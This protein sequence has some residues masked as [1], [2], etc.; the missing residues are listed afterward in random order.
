MFPEPPDGAPRQLPLVRSQLTT[1]VSCGTRRRCH[2]FGIFP[3]SCFCTSRVC[4]ST[5]FVGF[6]P[7][8]GIFLLSNRYHC[9]G[10]P[11]TPRPV[12]AGLESRSKR[13]PVAIGWF[14]S[15]LTDGPVTS[16][17]KS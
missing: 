2:A 4:S 9:S 3:P 11:L 16:A 13:L 8:R 17:S 6:G 5:A 1:A 12:V 7:A 10:V 14:W 15:P